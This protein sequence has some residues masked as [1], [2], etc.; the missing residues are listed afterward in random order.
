MSE[1]RD[2]KQWNLAV[3]NAELPQM[4]LRTQTKL[5]DVI[6]LYGDASDAF[7]DATEA[8]RHDLGVAVEGLR[9]VTPK[10][11]AT[12]IRDLAAGSVA[13]QKG[14]MVRT[15]GYQKKAAHQVRA[16]Q[17]RLNTLK[18]LGKKLNEHI[19]GNDHQ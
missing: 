13:K 12:L 7:A 14:D 18:F 9:A 10:I 2:D 4:L 3:I 8:Y 19:D 16:M 11:P 6:E 17:E 15:E 1:D 5:E